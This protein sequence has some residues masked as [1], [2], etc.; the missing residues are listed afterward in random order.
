[1]NNIQASLA[2][3]G[4]SVCA[5]TVLANTPIDIPNSDTSIGFAGKIHVDVIMDKGVMDNQTGF[6]P[7]TIETPNKSKN[8]ETRLSAG[9]SKIQFMTS[10]QLEEDSVDTLVEWDWFNSDNSSG[11]H[12]TQLW[13][14]YKGLGGGQTFSVF[15]DIST[16][17]NTLEY[18]GPNSMVFVRQPQV[19][20]T[21]PLS[22]GQRVAFAIEKPNSAVSGLGVTNSAHEP[23]PDFTAHWRLE[24]EES[25]IQV[26]GILRQLAFEDI[27]E[28]LETALGYGLNVTGNW[29]FTSADKL[30][31][32]F[33]VGE[34]IGRYVND[35]SWGRY[36]SASTG[37]KRGQNNDAVVVNNKLNALP[38]IGFYA[39]FDHAWTETLNTN[40]GYGYLEVDNEKT[41]AADA[42]K[43]SSF[44]VINV[45]YQ[46]A[47]P[48]TIGTELQWGDY[49]DKGGA[50]DDGLRWQSSV[51]YRF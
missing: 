21:L 3:L 34:G 2:F 14:E 33:T 50:S 45:L 48:V 17:P 6:S 15:M 36:D 1:M 16:F 42:F 47:K 43:S 23:M 27:N 28:D 40:I 8:L 24:S 39:F 31:A 18:W 12:L 13:A 51:I 35:T 22:E 25:H 10:T 11:F 26:A 32:S 38:L 37:A 44:A 46:L 20:Y 49:E 4:L 9:Q 7:A 19:R 29:Q 30:S 41:Q 5:N